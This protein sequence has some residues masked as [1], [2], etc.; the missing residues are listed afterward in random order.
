MQLKEKGQIKKKKITERQDF[1][2]E[3]GMLESRQESAGMCG[4]KTRFLKCAG[5]DERKS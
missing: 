2:E 5:R 3:V 4:W 1:Q